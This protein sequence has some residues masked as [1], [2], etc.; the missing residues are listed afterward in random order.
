MSLAEAIATACAGRDVPAQVL[1]DAFGTI[2]DGEASPV[3]TARTMNCPLVTASGNSYVP[4]AATGTRS[5]QLHVRSGS[6]QFQA[7]ESAGFVYG[8]NCT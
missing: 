5:T 7:W 2:A 1:E 3:Q 6:R 4:S 8:R